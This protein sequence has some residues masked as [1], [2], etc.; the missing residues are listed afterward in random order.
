M[1]DSLT[2]AAYELMADAATR[3]GRRAAGRVLAP[4]LSRLYRAARD[5]AARGRAASSESG[6]G[7]DDEVERE[8]WSGRLRHGR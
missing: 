4:S 6:A 5:Q 2:R 1:R 7:S 8:R 3:G